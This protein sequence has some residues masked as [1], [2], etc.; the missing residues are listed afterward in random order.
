MAAGATSAIARRTL[1]D[2]RVRD[3]SFAALFALVTFSSASAY[4][5]DYPTLHER[6]NFAHTFGGNASVRLFYGEPFDLLTVGGFTAWRAGGFLTIFAA[7]SGMLAAVRALR[8]EEDR[9]SAE[10]LIAAPLSR[11]RAFASALAGCAT[12]LCGI[13]AVLTLA[14]LAARLPAGES[15]YLASATLAPAAVFLGVGALASQIAPSRRV[16]LEL[17]GGALMAALVVRVAADTT[18]LHWLR[19]LS[20]LGW[21]EQMRPFTGARPAVLALPAAAALLAGGAAWRI[22]L[23]RDL[24]SGLLAS[25]DSAEPRLRGLSSA[26]AFA[27]RSERVSFA[28]WVLGSGF[29]AFVIGVISKTV[30]SVGISSSL[31]RQLARVGVS[32]LTPAGYIGLCFLFFL[33]FV[34]A[35]ACAQIAA[36]RHEE[37]EERLQALL[38]LPLGRARWL[39]G[40]LGLALAGIVVLSLADATLAWAGAAAAHAG[41]SFTSMLEAGVNCVPVAVLFLGLAALAFALLPRA[42]GAIAYGLLAVAFIWQ[43]LS[44]VLQAPH[45][46][47]GLSPFDHV[48]LAPE[49]PLQLGAAGVMLALALLLAALALGAFRRR[50]LVGA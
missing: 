31:R 34:S 40:R 45:W 49:Q 30:S 50:D 44:G 15:A 24:G 4:R 39:G 23:R 2:S 1:A 43:L 47:R 29:F 37:S 5:S 35:F 17:A 19:W 27:L 14:L 7:L 38:A 46:L 48:G 41:V 25:R 22:W 28:V 26:T 6:L 42:S 9:G 10:L 3:L 20:P 13:W 21:S 12:A 18:S 36:A 32:S 33:L 11:S 16:A 8:G